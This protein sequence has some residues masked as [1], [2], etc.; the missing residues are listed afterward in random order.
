M[1]AIGNQIDRG[2]CLKVGEIFEQ[3]VLGTYGIAW[4]APDLDFLEQHAACGEEEVFRD[5]IG[6]LEGMAGL[7]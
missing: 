3:G 6:I 7:A 5:H 1:D 2:R 4:R